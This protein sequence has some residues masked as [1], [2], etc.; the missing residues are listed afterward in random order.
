VL[1]TAISHI[2][3]AGFGHFASINTRP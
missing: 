1:M 2:L 3:S